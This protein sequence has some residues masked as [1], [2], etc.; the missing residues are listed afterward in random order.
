M[1]YTDRQILKQ[2]LVGL[3]ASLPMA[4]VIKGVAF[5]SSDMFEYIKAAD[6]GA[7]ATATAETD[8][9]VFLI[10]PGIVKS[11]TYVPVSGSVVADPANNAVITVSKR[12]TNGANL[13]TV[14]TLTTN[15]AGLGAATLVQRGNAAC[16]LTPANVRCA[17]GSTLTFSIAKGGTGVVVRQGFFI[18]EVEWD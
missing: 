1:A 15:L 12:D 7:A 11:I 18:V 4:D 14:G 9:N 16:V 2:S 8:L 17:A 6:D 3:A 5:L 10:R 13:T